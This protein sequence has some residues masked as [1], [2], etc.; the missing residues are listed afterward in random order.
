MEVSGQLHAPAALPQGKSPWYPLDRRLGGT[1]SPSGL[2]RE[3]KILDPTRTW[4]PNPKSSSPYP[5]AIPT[6]L[7]RLLPMSY[8]SLKSC[9]MTPESR[10]SGAW[11]RARCPLMNNWV[12]TKFPLQQLAKT[13]FWGN[14][15]ASINQSIAKRLSHIFVEMDETEDN[16]EESTVL[17]G[18]LYLVHT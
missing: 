2:C 13:H 1:H 8:K 15:Y 7:S 10:I 14:K 18:D 5:V 17:L 4:N 6:A 9:D 3:E 11:A 12:N 16:T